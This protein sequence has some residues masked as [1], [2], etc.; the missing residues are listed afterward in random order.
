[1]RLLLVEDSERL[2]R[3]LK[4]GLDRSGHVVD[5]ATD[6]RM[7]LAR[8]RCEPYDVVILDLMLPLLDGLEVLRHLRE[9]GR[10]VPVLVLTARDDVEDR[11]LG[12]RRGAD[13]YLGK[14]FAF[15]ELL[16]RIEG[17]GRRL[18]GRTQARIV[19]GDLEI[20]TAARRVTRAGVEIPL[21]ARE[22]SVLR[23]LADRA[24]ESVP[25]MEIEDKVY[26]E[27]NFPMS[28]AVPVAI[29]RL[30]QKLGEPPLVHTRRGLGYCLQA[31]NR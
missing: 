4:A 19:I 31:E 6:G 22:Y 17:L 21:D 18:H 27:D 2:A 14:P 11:V 24:G 15:E 20:D 8:A 12:L 28:N 29:R 25:R 13:D 16:A 9:E 7:G 26:G 30:R 23:L 10:D 3:S 5:V 1:M